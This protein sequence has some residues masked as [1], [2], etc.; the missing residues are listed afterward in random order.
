[1]Q[2]VFSWT[3]RVSTWLSNLAASTASVSNALLASA[4]SP[5][6]LLGIV[7][8]VAILTLVGGLL[9]CATRAWRH[10]RVFAVERERLLRLKA[11][12]SNDASPRLEVGDSSPRLEHGRGL[13]AKYAA[14]LNALHA[15]RSRS[16]LEGRR[17]AEEP[18]RGP[19]TLAR[20]L[21][22]GGRDFSID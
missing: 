7:A 2:R 18:A 20:E 16:R 6:Q 12:R 10:Y 17:S 5:M 15:E 3:L 13:G 9:T 8:F 11:P 14:A 21:T 19:R 22:R 4:P 1:M